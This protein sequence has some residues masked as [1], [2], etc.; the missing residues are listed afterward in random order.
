MKPKN[1]KPEPK[2]K[3]EPLLLT[4]VSELIA[5]APERFPFLVE[6]LLLDVGV[7]FISGSPKVGKS[8]FARQLACDIVDGGKFLDRFPVLLPGSVLYLSLEGNSVVPQMHF[9]A[10]APAEKYGRLY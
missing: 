9:K 1:K 6:G 5:K 10:L 3:P 4:S 7:S 8:T 2:P